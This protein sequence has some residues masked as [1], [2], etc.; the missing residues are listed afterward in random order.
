MPTPRQPGRSCKPV[1]QRRL[2]VTT[3]PPDEDLAAAARVMLEDKV[4]A[5]PVVV[6]GRVVGILTETDLLRQIVRSAECCCS[7]VPA[8]VVS[9]P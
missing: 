9:F 1:D 5:L 3:T 8:I 7:D 6:D 2:P 4:G